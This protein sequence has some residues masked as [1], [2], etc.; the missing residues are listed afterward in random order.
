MSKY[1]AD[2]NSCNPL[3]FPTTATIIMIPILLM[4]KL[5]LREGNLSWVPQVVRVDHMCAGAV[6][7]RV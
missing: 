7:P 1:F 5:K 6:C 2:I 3:S 4:R